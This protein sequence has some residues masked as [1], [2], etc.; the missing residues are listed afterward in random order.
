VLSSFNLAT[1]GSA[2]RTRISFVDEWRALL[3][4]PRLEHVAVLMETP[5]KTDEHG[6]EDWVNDTKHVAKA[7][8]LIN[9]EGCIN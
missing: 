7:R 3:Q 4:D 1:I 9:K 6:K 8:E 2:G 5:I